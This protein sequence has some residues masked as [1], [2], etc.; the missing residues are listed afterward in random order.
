[1][2]VWR[3]VWDYENFGETID[4]AEDLGWKNPLD[5]YDSFED[6]DPKLIDESEAEAL[7]FIKEN[8]YAVRM[9]G[10]WW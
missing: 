9:H 2:E 7:D 3:Q 4:F 1:M 8:G 6:V 10:E 5:K